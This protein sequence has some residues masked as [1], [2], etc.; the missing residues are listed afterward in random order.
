MKY[1]AQLTIEGVTKELRVFTSSTV[2]IYFGRE[3]TR[4]SLAYAG[5]LTLGLVA[6]SPTRT[7]GQLC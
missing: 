4:V 5:I 6:L 1:Y 7:E 3:R 2:M